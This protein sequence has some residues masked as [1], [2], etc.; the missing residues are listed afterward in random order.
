MTQQSPTFTNRQGRIYTATEAAKAIRG[1]RALRGLTEAQQANLSKLCADTSTGWWKFRNGC[2][3]E[4]VAR[5]AY[6]VAIVGTDEDCE[7]A[8]AAIVASAGAAS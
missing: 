3:L 7:K 6:I 4:S 2:L 1:Y 8:A 5:D